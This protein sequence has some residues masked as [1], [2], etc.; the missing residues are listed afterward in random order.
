MRAL[1]LLSLLLVT[2]A[3][4]GSPVNPHGDP[5]ACGA[6]HDPATDGSASGAVRPIVKNCRSCHPT[7]DMH[8]VGVAPTAQVIPEGWPLENGL[9]VCSTCHGEPAHQDFTNNQP[10]YH[11][12]GP[13]EVL[14]DLCYT[15]HDRGGYNRSD[16][17]HPESSRSNG[18]P[19]CAAC[20]SGPPDAGASP[21]N[22][23]LRY[24][25]NRVC[26][27]C[28]VSSVHLGAPMHL[29]AVLA[30]DRAAK[31]PA[32]MALLNGE[33][34]CW[35]CHEVHDSAK[36]PTGHQR[37]VAQGLHARILASDWDNLE[38]EAVTW[39]GDGDPAHPRLL[40]DSVTDGALCMHCHGRGP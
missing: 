23:R 4:A 39:P 25:S 38:G 36:E 20:H 6:C 2:R 37:T 11:R 28:H 15:C 9:V 18:D 32:S 12:G 21:E 30:P 19:T 8:P 7:A 10:P 3:Y 35:T 29:G 5:N 31:L 14:S 17:H 26:V 13:Y 1:G 27:T 24:A 34:M 22:A 33:I 16:P 40:A